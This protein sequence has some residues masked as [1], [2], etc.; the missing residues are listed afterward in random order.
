MRPSCLRPIRVLVCCA[1][2]AV[3]A[4]VALAQGIVVA[5]SP[6]APRCVPCVVTP[7]GPI[8]PALLRSSSRV[9]VELADRVLRYEVTETFVNRGGPLGEADYLFPLP[10]GAAFQDLQ[11]SING[12][13][14]AGE[15]LDAGQAR[16]V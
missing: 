10:A 8:T 14:V 4:R 16:S 13:L 7:C 12:E 6:C 2:V 3:A 5:P 1:L 11:L 15:V 9:H